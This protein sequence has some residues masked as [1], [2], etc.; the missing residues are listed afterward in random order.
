MEG[1]AKKFYI[2]DWHYGHANCIFFDNRPFK[3]MEHMNAEL[4]RR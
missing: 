1:K 4:V 3:S 2:A